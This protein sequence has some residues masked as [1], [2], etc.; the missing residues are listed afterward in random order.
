M[1][2]CVLT[3]RYICTDGVEA[4]RGLQDPGD[5]GMGYSQSKSFVD[6]CERLH[7][8][9]IRDRRA[10]QGLLGRVAPS[11]GC[12]ARPVSRLRT[13]VSSAGRAKSLGF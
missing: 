13:A 2:R 4:N 3:S 1:Y 11:P 5:F 8:P 9:Y 6:L 12:T 7:A 10:S